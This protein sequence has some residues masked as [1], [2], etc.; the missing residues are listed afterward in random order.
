MS[1][2]PNE[3]K[4][5]NLYK[6][7][8]VPSEDNKEQTLRV[9]RKQMNVDGQRKEVV[10][11]DYPKAA[12]LSHFLKD[13]DFPAKKHKILKFVQEQQKLSDNSEYQEIL[14]LLRKIEDKQYQNVFEVTNAA[15]LV[16]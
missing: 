4:D 12:T 8:Q 11:N 6:A 5:N 9:A 7:N 15:G 3:A 16:R 1:S 14:S 2:S 10:V 13:L